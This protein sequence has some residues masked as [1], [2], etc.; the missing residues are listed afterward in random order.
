MNVT[1]QLPR[2]VYNTTAGKRLGKG[3]SKGGIDFQL[4]ENRG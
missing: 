3:K 4:S 1:D 2:S